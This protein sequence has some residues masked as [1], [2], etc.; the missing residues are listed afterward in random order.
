MKGMYD[1]IGRILGIEYEK[2]SWTA[3][4]DGDFQVVYA[5][6]GNAVTIEFIDLDR[7]NWQFAVRDAE[8]DEIAERE[9]GSD[10]VIDYRTGKYGELF[11]AAKA[12]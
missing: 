10:K 5:Y 9:P 7:F 6:P 11:A 2:V 1:W 4:D 12:Y 8:M 3:A